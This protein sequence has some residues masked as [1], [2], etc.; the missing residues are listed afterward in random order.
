MPRAETAPRMFGMETFRWGNGSGSPV[1]RKSVPK[2]IHNRKPRQSRVHFL[3]FV[4]VF[5]FLCSFFRQAFLEN[6]FWVWKG[7]PA[8]R[9][10][11]FC[12][13][14]CRKRP[15][16]R[17]RRYFVYLNIQIF[18][19]SS[20]QSF[21]KGLSFRFGRG[22]MEEKMRFYGSSEISPC[23][24]C[25]Q[26]CANC[27]ILHFEM[28]DFAVNIPKSDRWSKNSEKTLDKG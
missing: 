15:E 1:V 13:R 8:Q 21:L 7:I 24:I 6:D 16:S 5:L 4:W 10:G 26:Q 27:R 14:F 3:D 22:S 28:T 20:L 9:E 18:R 12:F 25:G 11:R 23:K 17:L 2:R 19:D